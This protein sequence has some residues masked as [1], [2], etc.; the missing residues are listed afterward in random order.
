M[1][2]KTTAEKL[3]IRINTPSTQGKT[4]ISLHTI[5]ENICITSTKKKVMNM[6]C[7]VLETLYFW[8]RSSTCALGRL[9]SDLYFYS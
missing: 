9:L 6:H 8:K 2:L 5:F 4:L 7:N 3:V 1:H